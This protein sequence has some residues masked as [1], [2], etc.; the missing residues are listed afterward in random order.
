MEIRVT[1]AAL[2]GPRRVRFITLAVLAISLGR[3]QAN[4]ILMQSVAQVPFFEQAVQNGA[5]SEFFAGTATDLRLNEPRYVSLPGIMKAK[6]KP[7]EELALSD[8]NV[9]ASSRTQVLKLER[10]PQRKAGV[11]VKTVDELMQK[12]KQEAKVI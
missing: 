12:L 2:H 6:K 3:L 5:F 8:L 9:E 1:E 7:L 4:T 11:R 10:P